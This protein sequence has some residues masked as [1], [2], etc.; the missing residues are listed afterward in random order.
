MAGSFAVRA[1]VVDSDPALIGDYRQILGHEASIDGADGGPFGSF[2]SALFGSAVRHPQFPQVDLA[3]FRRGR[4]AVDAVRDAVENGVAFLIAYIDS[5]LAPGLDGFEAAERIRAVDERIQ[6]VIASG[7]SSLHPVEIAN[8]V[9]PA[10]RLS[11]VKKPFHPFEIQQALL[12]SLQRHR[13]ERREAVAP[14]ISRT[15]PSWPLLRA[16]LDKIPAGIVIFDERHQLRVANAYMRRL[17]PDMHDLLVVGTD[18]QAIR[19]HTAGSGAAVAPQGGAGGWPWRFQ[20]ER[21]A[22]LAE[23]LTD[24]GQTICVFHDAS[25]LARREAAYWRSLHVTNL[26]GTLSVL[27]D[28][29]E[30]WR[31]PGGKP[32]GYAGTAVERLRSLAQRRQS[33][34]QAVDVGNFL[35]QMVRRVQQQLPAGI[36]IETV[37]D[38]GLWLAWL[39]PDGLVPALRELFANACAAMAGHGRIILSVANVRINAAFV[40]QRPGLSTGD[41]VRMS[42][43]DTGRGGANEATNRAPLSAQAASGKDP[44]LGLGLTIVQAYVVGCGGFLEVDGGDGEGAV[45]HLYFPRAERQEPVDTA[46]PAIEAGYGG[47][48]RR[49]RAPM[50]RLRRGERAGR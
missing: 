31:T 34:P 1:L 37:M 41:Y 36:E 22:L 5:N 16:F 45:V 13:T 48:E 3:V 19:Q 26:I 17:F 18:Y 42:V 32:G 33:I 49:G 2:E 4:D 8:R 21:R 29:V 35:G 50:G 40:T 30:R 23:S 46:E 38:A 15:D 10:S 20:G 39:D 12:A 7:H 9:P 14:T 11:Y 44:H 24:G 47:R 28:N 6:I 27:C 25:E 43:H